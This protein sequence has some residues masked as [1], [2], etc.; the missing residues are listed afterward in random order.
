MKTT[1]SVTPCASARPR[2][3]RGVRP[4]TDEQ[5]PGSRHS[6]A[7]LRQRPQELVLALA[8]DQ[9]GH[10]RHDRRVAQAVA[11]AQGRPRLRVGPEGGGVDPRGQQL[12]RGVRTERG[13]EPAAR[14]AGDDRDDVRVVPDPPQ[15]LP[16]DR[17]HGPADLVPVRARHHPPDPGVAAQVGPQQR[18]RCGRAEPHGRRP[19]R[20]GELHGPPGDRRHRQHQRGGVPVHR[21]GRRGVELRRS[22]PRRGVDGHL[23]RRQ[24]VDQRLQVVLD[25]AG[26]RGEVVGHQQG[27]R[28]ASTLPA[29]IDARDGPG[30]VGRRPADRAGRRPPEGS[31]RSWGATGGGR[32]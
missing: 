22:G 7:Q 23:A 10:A 5:E 24:P 26:A 28:H 14:V 18:E 8:G 19:V 3:R 27:A 11:A 15:R 29:V 4:V 2:S 16:G 25:P 9:P 13:G 20:A 12:E 1:C 31:G 30:C 21:V 6:G 32:R 17:Q